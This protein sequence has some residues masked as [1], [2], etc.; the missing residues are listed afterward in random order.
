M[1]FSLGSLAIVG[2]IV[3]AVGVTALLIAGVLVSD[4]SYFAL[5]GAA[6]GWAVA[7][8]TAVQVRRLQGQ[9]GDLNRQV[10][11]LNK[12]VDDVEPVAN[13]MARALFR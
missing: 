1:R 12:R 9:V 11:D 10:G 4:W 8:L 3:V 6:P 7:V 5:F 13:V 2:S